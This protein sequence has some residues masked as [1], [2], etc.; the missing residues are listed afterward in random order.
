[1]VNSMTISS[2][3]GEFVKVSAEIRSKAPTDGALTPS[4]ATDYPLLGKHVKFK[5]ATNKAG[6]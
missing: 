2:A 5:L 1:M 4:Y 3:L 6:L